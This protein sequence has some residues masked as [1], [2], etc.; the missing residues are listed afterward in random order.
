MTPTNNTH[1]ALHKALKHSVEKDALKLSSNFTYLTMLKVAKLNEE[2][3]RKRERRSLI[4][5]IAIALFMII[6]GGTVIGVWFGEEI[7]KSF[8][9]V[10]SSIGE[11]F[12]KDTWTI[13]P[14]MIIFSLSIAILLVADHVLRRIYMKRHPDK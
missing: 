10:G 9:N 3:A 12:S 6:S 8:S 5:T 4:W 11:S 14:F 7:V 13:T 1:S 2:M